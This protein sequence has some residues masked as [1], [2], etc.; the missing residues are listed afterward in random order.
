MTNGF[1]EKRKLPQQGWEG[2]RPEDI[3]RTQVLREQKKQ[4][5]IDDYQKRLARDMVGIEPFALWGGLQTQDPEAS[6]LAK[7][8]APMDVIPASAA[9]G[10]GAKIGAGLLSAAATAYLSRQAWKQPVRPGMLASTF[11]HG[12]PH[13]WA[14]EPG[15]PLGRPRLGQKSGQG[16]TMEGPG[17]YFGEA[18]RTGE[19]YHQ[20]LASEAKG[21][22]SSD[23]GTMEVPGW[24]AEWLSA[25][26]E[27]TQLGLYN[28]WDVIGELQNKIGETT[29][30]IRFPRNDF[31]VSYKPELQKTLIEQQKRLDD[32]KNII[33]DPDDPLEYSVQK[34]GGL[35]TVDI[36]DSEVA[37]LLDLDKPILEQTP[38]VQAKLNKVL[39]QYDPSK[40]QEWGEV[41]SGWSVELKGPL[42]YPEVYGQHQKSVTARTY[43]KAL[44]LV[45]GD[46]E[47]ARILENAGIPG[48]KYLDQGSRAAG[49]GTYNAVVFSEDLLKRI[50]V[51]KRE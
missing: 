33:G 22:I 4:Q 24:I 2:W 32:F 14:S 23:R 50:K 40:T 31:D 45:L 44:R 17:I 39:D 12:T 35:Y 43:Y 18:R 9:I 11:F 25:T 49:E 51:L 46:D 42:V 19:W 13:T 1:W 6:V 47:A 41:G 3:E 7:Y 5:A 29:T 37:G 15:L 10:T 26:T 16:A 30:R 48:I 34:T 28:V 27:N 20:E 8:A 36:P 21:I 38:Y